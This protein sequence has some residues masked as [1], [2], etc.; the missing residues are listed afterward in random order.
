MRVLVAYGTKRGGN[1]A[2]ARAVA[3]G[4]QAVGHSV[5]V[6]AS[7]QVDALDRWDAV[8]VGGA[9]Y[10]W[11]WH[12]NAQRFIQRNVEDLFQAQP[13]LVLR[14]IEAPRPDPDELLAMPRP[15]PRLAQRSA[16][17]PKAA[18]KPIPR[19]VLSARKPPRDHT[20]WVARLVLWLCLF[21]GVTAVAGG[22]SVLIAAGEGGTPAGLLIPGL[23]L[24][25][26]VGL[27]NLF[28][29]MLEAQRLPLGEL[30]A[31]VGG[32]ALC[33]W[34]VVQLMMVQTVSWLQLV[35]FVVGLS[36]VGGALW[37]WRARQ[38]FPSAGLYGPG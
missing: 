10:A 25:L 38:R 14:L 15:P 24:F 31:S 29:A 13:P 16:P 18:A 21:S 23:I 5:D 2:L 17:A 34:I 20:P 12:R 6:I 9:P 11:F 19:P 35:F 3:T 37:L 26:V 36:T 27:G 7:T 1:E 33:G 30:V 22:V 28:A 32:A 4:L 8:V